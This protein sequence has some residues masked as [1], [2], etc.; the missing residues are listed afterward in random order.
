[1]KKLGYILLKT[2]TILAVDFDKGV[3]NCAVHLDFRWQQIPRLQNTVGPS[4]VFGLTLQI[5]KTF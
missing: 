2:I 1:V 5:A 3:K 4:G